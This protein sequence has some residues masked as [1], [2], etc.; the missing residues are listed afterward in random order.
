MNKKYHVYILTNDNF[1]V[2]YTGVTGNLSTR[3]FDHK[4]GDGSAFTH[5]YKTHQLVY[6]EA[7]DSADQAIEWE[8]TI[9]KW[10]RRKKDALI[11]K[12]K[13]CVVGSGRG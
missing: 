8:K 10:S 5:K 9:K 7:F 2:L 3:V 4:N 11:Y 13:F 6:A 12:Q 1:T